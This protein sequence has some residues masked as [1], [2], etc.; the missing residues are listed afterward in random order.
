MGDIIM[1]RFYHSCVDWPE[2]AFIDGGLSEM[3]DS[4]IDITRRTFLKHVDD[5][6]LA[7]IAEKLGYDWHHSQGLT[8]AGDWSIGYYRSKLYGKRVYYFTHSAIEY[9]FIKLTP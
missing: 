4:A 2:D 7:D 9:V 1:Y 8:M 5:G 6:E 3:I